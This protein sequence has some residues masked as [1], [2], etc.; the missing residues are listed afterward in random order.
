MREAAKTKLQTRLMAFG[1]LLGTVFVC[2]FNWINIFNMAGLNKNRCPAYIELTANWARVKDTWFV[3]PLYVKDTR[4]LVSLLLLLFSCKAVSDSCNPMDCSHRAPLS[5]GFP[6][7]DYWT[8]LPFPPPWHLPAPGME[9][10]SPDWQTG[11]LPLSHQGSPRVPL[12]C[13]DLMTPFSGC[14]SECLH[15][16]NLSYCIYFVAVVVEENSYLFIL[17]FNQHVLSICMFSVCIRW[18]FAFFWNF[19]F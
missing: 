7:R 4:L 1:S 16:N 19:L 2:V 13:P 15:R 18:F 14:C 12:S 3:Y 5:M 9:P 6:R 11:P 17:L 10:E 8:G